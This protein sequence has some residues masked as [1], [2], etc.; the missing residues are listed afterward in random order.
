MPQAIFQNAIQI[1]PD[2]NTVKAEI[3]NPVAIDGNQ[4]GVSV[5]NAISLFPGQSIGI[6]PDQ[7]RVTI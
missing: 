1:D 5:E 2:S 7:N 4:N 6:D 3:Q